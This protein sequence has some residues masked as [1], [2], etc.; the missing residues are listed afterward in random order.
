MS[1][2]PPHERN[3]S[4][5]RARIISAVV[6]AVLCFS[7]VYSGVYGTAVLA[8]DDERSNAGQFFRD[9]VRLPHHRCG[10]YRI[11]LASG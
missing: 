8:D 11:S 5:L 7:L 4:D 3:W 10:M 2:T 6:M 1:A 9:C